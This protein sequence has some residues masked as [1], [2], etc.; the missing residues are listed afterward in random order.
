M[1]EGYTALGFVA[2]CTERLRLRLLVTGRHL[3]PPRAPGQDR[4]HARRALGRPRR[5]GDRS[6]LV[7]P[8]APRPRR[9][10]P[11]RRPSASSGSRRPSRSACRCG[12]TTTAPTRAGTTSSTRRCAGPRRSAPPP[13][14]PHRRR[15][16]R[17]TLRL[18]AQ[19]ADACNIFGGPEEVTH[20]LDVLPPP[21]RRGGPRPGR[22]RGDGHVPRTSRRHPSSTTWCAPPRSSPPSAC[23]RWSRERWATTRPVGSSR[24]SPRPWTTWPP[25]TRSHP[26]PASLGAHAAPVTWSSDRDALGAAFV[27][28]GHA[29]AGP[30][31]PHRQ[32]DQHRGAPAAG[33][34][35]VAHFDELEPR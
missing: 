6:G 12:A 30:H 32:H 8:R 1:L 15:G 25:W 23:R 29:P 21:L 10:V 26:D 4:D 3:P 27:G 35:G 11:A 17:K 5:A 20:K 24:P 34:H 14:H 33:E 9:A 2:G 28:I 13:A 22:D 18:V 19:Y 31:S 16:E 7:R